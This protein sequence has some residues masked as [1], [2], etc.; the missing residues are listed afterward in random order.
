MGCLKSST[1]GRETQFSNSQI[2]FSPLWFLIQKLDHNSALH[3]ENQREIS[4]NKREISGQHIDP[5]IVRELHDH[6]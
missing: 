4:S 3:A 5:Q 1:L 2:S 6:F